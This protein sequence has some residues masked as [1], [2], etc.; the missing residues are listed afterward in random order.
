MRN[1]IKTTVRYYFMTV[2]MAKRESMKKSRK[3]E[4]RKAGGR[5]GGRKEGRKKSKR[6]VDNVLMR[7]QDVWSHW[8]W[9]SL[10][11]LEGMQ[12]D[13]ETLGKV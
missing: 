13:T 10:T 3:K 5:Q 4:V 11:S 9:N 6:N 7:T 8:N 2:I 12:I 1:E